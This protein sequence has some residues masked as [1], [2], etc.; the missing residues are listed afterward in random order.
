VDFTTTKVTLAY[1][2]SVKYQSGYWRDFTVP[3]MEMMP[4]TYLFKFEGAGQTMR[5]WLTISGCEMGGRPVWIHFEESDGTPI[6]GDEAWY[7][8]YYLPG[9]LIYAGQSDAN[10]DIFVLIPYQYGTDK[11]DQFK[12]EDKSFDEFKTQVDIAS[13]PVVTFKTVNVTVE[14]Q[15]HDLDG[16]TDDLSGSEAYGLNVNAYG[17]SRQPFG[18]GTTTNYQETMELLPSTY[19]YTF[20][21]R[22]G[23]VWKSIAGVQV[24]PTNNVVT[25]STG[26]V[27]DCTGTVVKY[28]SYNQSPHYFPFTDYMDVLT[29]H[30]TL[31]FYDTSN[32]L[33][34]QGD[35]LAGQLLEIGTC[36]P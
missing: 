36:P 34:Y 33:I 8:D 14:L 19:L 9:G 13:N 35:V 6:Q 24:T 22:Y 18:S 23:G 16:S 1:P 20:E 3:T 25:F 17:G 12:G 4:G 30:Y 5:Q 29:N 31:K 27:R 32:G 26:W 10:G 7:A 21:M 11:I 15:D 2:G 28:D